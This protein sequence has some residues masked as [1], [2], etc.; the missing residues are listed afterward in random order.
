LCSRDNRKVLIMK[1]ADLVF[2]LFFVF[3][4]IK[5]VRRPASGVRHSGKKVQGSKFKVLTTH[6]S[7]LASQ[8]LPSSINESKQPERYSVLMTKLNIV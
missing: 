2:M 8:L 6:D 4:C 5:G 3:I 7:P 1:A